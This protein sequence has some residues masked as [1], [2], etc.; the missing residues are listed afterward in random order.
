VK[1]EL[2]VYTALFGD[3]DRLIDP[4]ED[5]DNC[6]F[7]CFTDQENLKSD[8]WEIR[9]V[10][11]EID[12]VR[13]NRLYKIKPHLFLSE[14]EKSVYVDANIFIKSNPFYLLDTY[15]KFSNIAAPAHPLRNCIYDEGI[16]CI[17]NKK[18][19]QLEVDRQ[20]AIYK[21]KGFPK[22]YGLCE[23]NIIYRN[24]NESSIINLMNEWWIEFEN[25]AKRDQLSFFYCCWK[26]NITCLKM[27]ENAR[28]KNEFFIAVPHRNDSLIK[29]I[30]YFT[31]VFFIR[32]SKKLAS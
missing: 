21:M 26:N 23:M 28:N 30:Y 10:S 1:N 31:R 6:H 3:Y 7:I 9:L 11:S 8:I 29:R 14:Y 17:D 32:L 25:G 2:V 24:H 5:F 16:A 18:A 12:T 13:M 20:L 27:L 22:N 15:L 19:P 4:A